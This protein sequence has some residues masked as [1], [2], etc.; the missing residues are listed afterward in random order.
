VGLSPTA[1]SAITGFP[2]AVITG[3]SII[4]TGVVTGQ[5]RTDLIKAAAGLAAMPSGLNESG[6]DLGGLTL[7]PGVYTFNAA[8]GL[9][10]N[11]I[12]NAE[13]ENNAVWVFQIGSTFTTAAD[14]TVTV[15]NLG[16]NGGSDDGVF[17]DAGSAITFGAGN[18][19]VGNY[20]AG[21]SIT[22]GTGTFGAGRGLA[23]A[24]ISLD[25]NTLNALGGPD[26]GDWTGGLAYDSNGHVVAVPE[27]AA[28]LWLAPLG[29][30]GFVLWRRARGK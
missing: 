17:W 20:L 22:F 1:T 25:G 4:G 16:S 8:A 6:T 9:T 13:G 3:G 2:P 27:P 30:L 26:G 5:A 21:T 14:A 10:G 15:V 7:T 18:D 23:L 11:L 12:L 28:V 19:I 24:A 29:A